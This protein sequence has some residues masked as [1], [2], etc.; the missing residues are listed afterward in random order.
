MKTLLTTVRL[1]ER[2]MKELDSKAKK[3]KTNRTVV[4][5]KLLEEAVKSSKIEEA[6]QLYKENKITISEAAR[7]AQLTIGE[8]MEELAKRGAR[9]DL[10]IEE[11]KESLNAALKIFGTQKRA[12]K[13]N[14]NK[15]IQSTI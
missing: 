14:E 8:T 1:P 5:R 6:A 13:S 9:S 3:E 2:I 10:T 4:L 11:Y 12:A 15:H 7:M